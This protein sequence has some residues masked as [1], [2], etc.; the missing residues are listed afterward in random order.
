MKHALYCAA[1]A[2]I[3]LPVAASAQS[4]IEDIVVTAQKREQKLQDVP[5]TVKA[6]TAKGLQSAGATGTRD[7][8]LVTPGV[9]FT[10]TTSNGSAN[11]R[12]VAARGIGPGDEPSVPVYIDGVYQSTAAAGFFEFNNIERIEVLKGPQGTLFGRNALGGAI[13]IITLRPAF[14][15]TAKADLSYGTD[16][17]VQA[18]AYASGGLSSDLAVSLSFHGDRRDGYINNI[19]SGKDKAKAKSVGL[20]GKLLWTPTDRLELTLAGSYLHINDDTAYSGY[21][22]DGNTVV[23]RTN[24]GVVLAGPGETAVADTFMRVTQKGASATLDWDFDSFTLTALQSWLKTASV[25]RTDS[26]ATFDEYA[27][28]RFPYSDE[29]LSSEV[30]LASSGKRRLDWIGGVYYYHG[31]SA[32]PI[33]GDGDVFAA[34][35]T[36]TGAILSVVSKVRSRAYALFGEATFHVTDAFSFTGGARYS[37]ELRGKRYARSTTPFATAPGPNPLITDLIAPVYLGEAERTYADTSF[38]A[39]AQYKVAPGTMAFFTFSQGFKSGFYNASS[40]PPFLAL[41]PEK[42]NNFEGGIKSEPTSNLR[43]N[44]TAFYMKYRDMQVSAR[45]PTGAATTDVFNAA[46]AKNHGGELEV[47]W[48]PVNGLKLGLGVAYQHAR[49]EKFPGALVYFPATSTDAALTNPCQMGAGV[50]L[51]GN[52]SAT[53]DA[54]GRPLAKS[55]DWTASLTANYE[56]PAFGGKMEIGGVLY[57]SDNFIWDLYGTLDNG[58]DYATVNAHL[59]WATEDDRWKVTLFSRNATDASY[60]MFRFQGAGATYDIRARG[61]TY[62]LRLSTNFP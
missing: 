44:L 56:F 36:P 51:G 19:V 50:L 52:R 34:R 27:Y 40:A 26:D 5:I 60:P 48:L 6:I 13:N 35:S 21:P 31:N 9:V 12:G 16:N 43:V 14:D 7:L 62:G 15:F 30:R 61:A 53:C 47:E 17:E 23:L 20:R 58:G 32:Y 45:S 10:N 55:P 11:I 39:S 46:G 33:T 25:Q 18:N 29:S 2:T 24:P 22:L 3:A 37:H 54:S 42:V 57:W 28:A 8:T 41:E 49:Y 59:S 1:A 4:Q 38:R